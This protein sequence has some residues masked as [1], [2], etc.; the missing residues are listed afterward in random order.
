MYVGYPPCHVLQYSSDTIVTFMKETMNRQDHRAVPIDK[1]PGKKKQQTH[2]SRIRSLI[3]VLKILVPE[4][5]SSPKL[6][7]K[8]S[9][10]E[11]FE[12]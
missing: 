11:S 3:K 9:P 5:L 8:S 7:L 1:Y 10:E 12:S 6:V 4:K 2:L